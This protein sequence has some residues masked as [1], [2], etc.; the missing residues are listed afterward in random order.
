MPGIVEDSPASHEPTSSIEKKGDLRLSEESASDNQT[1]VEIHAQG[2]LSTKDLKGDFSDVPLGQ[3]IAPDSDD[4][5]VDPR[6]K[7][8]PIELVAKT[9]DLKNDPT[10]PILTFR[11]WMLSTF[12]VVVGCALSTFYYFK[13]YYVTV[14]SYAVQLLSWGMG[15]AMANYLPN[16]E[17]NWF[18]FK[19]NPNP[20]PWNAKEHALVVVAYW[21]SCYTAFG[22][23]PLSAI[24]L[25]YG[26][27]LNAG[28]SIAFLITTQMIGYGF[29]GLLRDILVR[30]PTMY[31]PGV[32]PNITLFNAMHHNPSATK[33]ALKYF[34]IVAATAFIWEWFPQ[35]IFPL[36]S[37]M[38]IICW[39]GHGNWKAWVLGSGT[40][41]FGLLDLSIDWNYGA[42]FSPLY[43]PLWSTMNT[44]LF[45]I[46]ICWVLYPIIYFTNTMN[47]QTFAPMDTGTY[48][49]N[50]S[51]YD[52]TNILT[53]S[54]TLNET[55][56]AEYGSP[57]WAPSYVFYWFWGFAALSAS[58]M[59]ALLW[60]GKEAWNGLRDAFSNRYN[61]YDDPYLKIM[62]YQ[63]RVPH[64]WYLTLLAICSG[65]AIAGL[66]EG[67]IRM[68]WWGFIVICLVS[69]LM[70]WPNGILWAVA[71]TAVGM[72]MFSDLLGGFLFPGQPTAMLAAYTYG[73]AVLEQNL[74]LI[75]DYKFGFYMKIPEREMFIGQVWGTLLGPFVNYG[76]SQILIT[77]ERRYLDGEL[78]SNNWDAVNSRYFYSTSIIWGILGPKRF[79]ADRYPWVYYSF[80]VG[81]AAVLAVWLVHRW[82]PHWKLETRFNPTLMFLAGTNWPYYPMANFF[83]S[84]LTAITFMG[85]L[86]KYKPAWWRKYNY[87]TGVGLDCGTQLMTLVGVFIVDLPN[88]SFPT[89][90]GNNPDYPDRCFPPAD[91]PPYATN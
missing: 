59:Y 15:V 55:A 27:S 53:A 64:W 58:L 50:G 19:W 6:L 76:V 70:T 18:G 39:M 24:E 25:F 8:Y 12:W 60:Y 84:F 20:A 65:L 83:M 48:T 89:W 4:V 45:T 63:K 86:R 68:P 67:Q 79:F 71:N 82:K 81:P 26:E 36:L 90:W 11:F 7:N 78:S 28:W 38:P 44:A 37:T 77:H 14:T 91:L 9:V 21:G 52:V 34:A 30:P 22:L 42:F 23:G 56:Y 74:N 40:Y 17:F 80:L 3:G 87:L 43:T 10:E 61:D 54:N 35:V 2:F 66:Y 13:P 29:A 32:L 88:L 75:S 47:A 41:G 33:K 1:D 31:Y 49:A 57:Y 69:F 46:F 16:R 85:Y 51:T 62:S 5:Y 72:G 73:Y